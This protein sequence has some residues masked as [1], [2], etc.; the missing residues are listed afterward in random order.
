MVW[1]KSDL[2]SSEKPWPMCIELCYFYAGVFSDL[3]G[4]HFPPSLPHLNK[5]WQSHN[6]SK[7]SVLLTFIVITF[8]KQSPRIAN[9]AWTV[10][11]CCQAVASLP[12][13]LSSTS[14]STSASTSAIVIK[15]TK[16]WVFALVSQSHMNQVSTTWLSQLVTRPGH[17][18]TQVRLV[19]LLIRDAP[20]YQ[21]CSFCNIFKRGGRVK[22]MLKKAAEFIKAYGNGIKSANIS[23]RMFKRMIG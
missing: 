2:K 14:T 16:F 13:T 17:D 1:L 20:L 11:T 23:Y 7:S 4:V 15:S 8:S 18:R 12:L 5:Y 6:G 9:C 3:L 22:S 10:R 19:R 21:S